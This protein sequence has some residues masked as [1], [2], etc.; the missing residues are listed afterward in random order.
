MALARA[1][2]L[3]LMKAANLIVVEVGGNKITTKLPKEELARTMKEAEDEAMQLYLR[4]VQ[5]T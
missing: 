5:K 4:E 2:N 1:K 3:S